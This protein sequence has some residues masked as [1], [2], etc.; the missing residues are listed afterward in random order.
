MAQN[1]IATNLADNNKYWDAVKSAIEYVGV[2][3][4]NEAVSTYST[5]INSL[6]PTLDKVD[7]LEQTK[8]EYETDFS[9]IYDAIV[10]KGQTP[11]GG[12]DT[13]PEA[14]G[15]IESGSD[16]ETI[17]QLQEENKTLQSSVDSLTTEKNNLTSQVSSLTEEKETLSTQVNTLTSENS[18]LTTEKNKLTSQVSSL[19]DEKNTLTNQVGTLTS[20]KNSLEST[21]TEYEGDFSDIHDAIVE[22]GQTPT[23]GYDT[24]ATAIRNITTGE[25]S[26]ELD[27][28]KAENAEL[29]TNVSTLTSENTSLNNTKTTYE[30]NFS[31]IHD[32]I[33]EKGQ[34]PTG[35]YD[36]YAL[37][38]RN[39]ETGGGS[40]SSVAIHDLSYMFD[41]S[42]RA[43]EINSILSC[44]DEVTNIDN[45][46]NN[47]V[48][49]AGTNVQLDLTKFTGNY[50]YQASI[51]NRARSNGEAT[52][53]VKTDKTLRALFAQ[54]GNGGSNSTKINANVNY[55]GT[56]ANIS[57]Y[58]LFT[59]CQYIKSFNI[60]LPRN[61]KIN[62]MNYMFASVNLS[63]NSD[64]ML[65]FVLPDL[66]LA[67]NCNMERMFVS[68]GFTSITFAKAL[69]LNVGKMRL[70]NMF[71]MAQ[72]VVAIGSAESPLDIYEDGTVRNT[73][74]E[75][76]FHNCTVL[77]KIYSSKPWVVYNNIYNTFAYCKALTEVPAVE[78][79]LNTVCQVNFDS[80]YENSSALTN[81]SVTIIADDDY[82]KSNPS[83]F[84]LN[85]CF[86]GCKSLVNV[87]GNLDMSY[88]NNLGNI[89]KGC[90]SLVEIATSGSI[91]GKISAGSL[92]L[93]L[94]ECSNFDAN[95]FAVNLASNISGKTRTIKLHSNVLSGLTD[96]IKTIYANKHYTLA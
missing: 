5:K 74:A 62:N 54:L 59:G 83:G 17:K 86:S 88:C 55:V 42:R 22:K 48:I 81:V 75:Y 16:S 82:V 9:N 66:P 85:S 52:I 76:M 14:I 96:D 19:T 33:V 70:T 3:V 29:K 89:F 90:S 47:C 35:G 49:P 95:T 21:K 68:C 12:Y 91:G 2:S 24:Y 27:K 30:S 53:N 31:D 32:A 6:K 60:S 40:G 37:A 67:D 28:L 93:D 26:E 13:Y 43:N 77:K 92:T 51:F 84:S 69:Y 41:G 8:S 4:G 45:C 58:D 7:K 56:D 1:D 50:R 44:A 57:A 38:I 73:N 94:S 64:C 15:L 80:V 71:Y 65:D 23:G 25:T 72:K 39:I 78:K 61:T 18:T 36:T 63:N 79:H 34:T 87:N 20:E 11:T 46:F 10:A